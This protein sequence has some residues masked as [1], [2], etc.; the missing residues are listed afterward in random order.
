MRPGMSLEWQHALQ[1]NSA[2]ALP[3]SMPRLALPLPG[4]LVG[5]LG[6]VVVVPGSMS[7]RYAEFPAT[8]DWNIEAIAVL[9]H[10]SPQIAALPTDLDEHLIHMP[11]SAKLTLPTAQ[12]PIKRGTE[13]AIPQAG[14]V[15]GHDHAA[16]GKW[17]VDVAEA[18][19]EPVVQPHGVSED[20]TWKPVASIEG[21]HRSIV[22]RGSEVDSNRRDKDDPHPG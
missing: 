6:P 5:H 10:C 8:C 17:V 13:I 19:G 7:S 16:L 4:V 21:F 18:R 1:E 2:P 15:V 14:H 22:L 11:D 20:R 12:V 9:V 3:T